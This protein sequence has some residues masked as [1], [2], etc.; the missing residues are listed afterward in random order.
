MAIDFTKLEDYVREIKELKA[1]LD[2][3]VEDARVIKEQLEKA[4]EEIAI[5][6]EAAKELV[7]ISDMTEEQ[8]A[9]LMVMYIPFEDGKEV[10]EGE[11]R[12]Y[13]NSLYI[14]TTTHITKQGLTP[15]MPNS[16]FRIF[17]VEE[18]FR[19]QDLVE[20][21]TEKVMTNAYMEGNKVRFR[22][23]IYESL[24]DFNISSPESN[25]KAWKLI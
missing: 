19:D 17:T 7:L 2:K 11:V 1:G 9:N 20:E 8:K 16:N 25:L 3:T 21:W 6:K 14:A 4:L 23:Q 5:A 10:K 24:K 12:R 13:N 18:M 22:G 15:D